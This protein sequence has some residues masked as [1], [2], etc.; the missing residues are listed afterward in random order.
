MND[1]NQPPSSDRE[2]TGPV[3]SP[4]PVIKTVQQCGLCLEAITLHLVVCATGGEVKG[5]PF[6]AELDCNASLAKSTFNETGFT[7]KIVWKTRFPEGQS[8]PINIQGEHQLRFSAK[9]INLESA[10]YYAETNGVVL[11]YPYIREFVSDLSFRCL[12]RNIMIRPLDVPAFISECARKR[13]E[14]L[15]RDAETGVRPDGD[16]SAE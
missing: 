2:P 6:V 9:G 7:A 11:A 15:T 10:S 5:H 16:E 14:R 3:V 4:L 1:G 12:G 8:A 13:R